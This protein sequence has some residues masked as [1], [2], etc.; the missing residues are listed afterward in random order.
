MVFPGQALAPD[1]VPLPGA[2]LP[3]NP[4]SGRIPG[5][6]GKEFGMDVQQ[7][8]AD[9]FNGLV[10]RNNGKGDFSTVVLEDSHFFVPGNGKSLVSL[11]LASERPIIIAS[12][13]NDS[14]RV[15]ERAHNEKVRILKIAPNE[16]KAL[17]EYEDGQQNLNEFYW[18]SS[19]QS[20]SGRAM[21]IPITATEIR[22]FNNTGKE[23]R[24]IADKSL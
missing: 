4:D 17:V 15:F 23:T 24:I 12:Q 2:Q 13:N 6:V 18:G 1:A 3:G 5:L 21:T 14:L 20:Q 11:S 22:L 19:F 9:A 8:K 7:G 16:V 10:L